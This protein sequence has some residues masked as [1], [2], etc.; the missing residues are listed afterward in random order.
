MPIRK[1]EEVCGKPTQYNLRT[2]E[3]DWKYLPDTHFNLGETPKPRNKD[4][5]M[6]NLPSR[7]ESREQL[8]PL[9]P[10]ASPPVEQP[11]IISSPP[12]P[13]KLNSAPTTSSFP[14]IPWSHDNLRRMVEANQMEAQ[15]SYLRR[16]L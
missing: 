10:R 14:I 4:Y 8:P 3:Y 9:S 15:R 13:V 2:C 12:L 6:Q 5:F 11:A 7:A 16:G 1:K